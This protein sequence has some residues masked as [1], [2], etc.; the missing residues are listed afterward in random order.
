MTSEGRPRF[1]AVSG[2]VPVAVLVWKIGTRLLGQ[3]GANPSAARWARIG[4][5]A[6]AI[7]GLAAILVGIANSTLDGASVSADERLD[8]ELR[9][10]FPASDAPAVTRNAR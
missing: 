1:A 2:A 9:D 6:A 5:A 3:A 7:T 10:T 8:D 4:A